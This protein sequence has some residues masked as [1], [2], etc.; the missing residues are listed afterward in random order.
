MDAGASGDAVESPRRGAQSVQ[1]LERKVLML[2]QEKVQLE[3]K[4][5]NC[6]CCNNRNEY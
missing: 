3:K 6:F 1:N 4:L 2:E 5:G